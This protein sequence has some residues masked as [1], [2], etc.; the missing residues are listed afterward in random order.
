V[1]FIGY[2]NGAV[3]TSVT[4]AQA[5]VTM[6]SAYM[7]ILTVPSCAKTG[8]VTVTAGGKSSN[9]LPFIVTA[10]SYS[11][12]CP[13]SPYTPHL[14]VATESLQFGVVGQA[15]SAT[16]NATGGIT[17]YSWSIASGTLPEGL[18]LNTDAGTISG[19]PIGNA[20]VVDV[21]FKVTD[22]S[23]PQLNTDAALNL[24]IESALAQR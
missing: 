5:T 21:T 12:S 13:E 24:T 18:T 23:S 22:S 10:G 20:G 8:L 1:Q 9:G 11:G 14:E 7:L 4:P 6:W 2:K 19:T 16:L 15:Y 3:D 17:P